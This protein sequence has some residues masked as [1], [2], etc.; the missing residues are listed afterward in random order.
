M[1]H[2]SRISFTEADEMV[3]DEFKKTFINK[4]NHACQKVDWSYGVAYIFINTNTT[5]YSQIL[6]EL[7]EKHIKYQ[8]IKIVEYSKKDLDSA[9]YLVLNPKYECINPYNDRFGKIIGEYKENCGF[10]TKQLADLMIR[11]IDLGKRD[12]LRSREGEQIIVSP[13]LKEILENYDLEGIKFRNVYTKGKKDIIAY[14]IVISNILPKLH[15]KTKLNIAIDA[16]HIGFV[17]YTM[18]TDG[19]LYYSS[20]AFKNVK[21]FNITSEYF[22]IG[23]LPINLKIV[24]QKVRQLLIKEK[25]KGIEFTPI[26]IEN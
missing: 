21:D 17:S 23:L 15:S 19:L 16:Q 10:Y 6:E 24:S 4:Y 12:I 13:R 7:E 2:L 25:I 26:F 20:D 18:E 5:E 14:Q 11:E 8:E 3:D 1:I 22:G 9:Q